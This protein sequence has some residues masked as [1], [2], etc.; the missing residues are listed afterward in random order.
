MQAL[1]L[2]F[3]I[4]LQIKATIKMYYINEIFF[5]IQPEGARSGTPNV[6]VRFSG[7]NLKCNLKEHGFFCDTNFSGGTP[8][9]LEELISKVQEVGGNCKN[10]IL[11]GGEPSLQYDA[12]LCHRLREAGYF[13]AMETNGTNEIPLDIY[14]NFVSCSPKTA[15]HTLCLLLPPSELRYV[16]AANQALPKP[17]LEADHYYL[18]PVFTPDMTIDYDS[19]T[20]CIELIKENPKW[21]LSIQ[22]HKLLHLR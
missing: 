16:L 15:E 11:T 1:A 22:W 13:I 19:L 20:W 14:P 12:A 21:K 10:V 9:L 6:F 8:F 17:R 5:S 2:P 18:S 3:F 7:C 4:Y